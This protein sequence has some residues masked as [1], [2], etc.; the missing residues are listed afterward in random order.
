MQSKSWQNTKKNYQ[1]FNLVDVCQI[2]INRPFWPQSFLFLGFNNEQ[3]KIIESIECETVFIATNEV[4]QI[5]S[6][7]EHQQSPIATSFGKA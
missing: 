5:V 1:S 6:S 2:E 4:L 7:G 3:Q